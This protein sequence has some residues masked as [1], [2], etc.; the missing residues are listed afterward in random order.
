MFD[1]SPIGM[2]RCDEDGGFRYVNAALVRMLG[3]ETC[4][5]LLSQNLNRDIYVDPIDRVQLLARYRPQGGVAGARVPWRTKQGR[6]VTVQI[7]GHVIES[8]DGPSFDASVLD[9]TEV[10]SANRELRKQREVLETTASMLDL[11][12]HQMSAIYWV[13]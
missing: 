8:A 3:Y 12:V 11:V 5:E 10:E 1:H 2:Y 6:H 13:V 7:Y 4:G 9:V